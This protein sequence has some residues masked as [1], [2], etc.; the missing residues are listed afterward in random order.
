MNSTTVLVVT[1]VCLV[2]FGLAW[3]DRNSK[4]T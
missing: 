1:V 2:F 3:H 4:G